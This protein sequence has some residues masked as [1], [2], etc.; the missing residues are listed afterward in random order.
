MRGLVAGP[1]DKVLMSVLCAKSSFPFFSF[2]NSDSI[3]GVSKV[4]LGEHL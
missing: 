3:V 1:P 4:D 2:R